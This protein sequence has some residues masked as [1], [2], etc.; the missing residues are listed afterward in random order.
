MAIVDDL[1]YKTTVQDILKEPRLAHYAIDY[2]LEAGPTLLRPY[3]LQYYDANRDFQNGFSDEIMITLSIAVGDYYTFVDPNHEQLFFEITLTPIGESSDSVILDSPVRKTRYKAIGSAK[4]DR[5]LQG[6][7]SYSD[8]STIMDIRLQLIPLPVYELRST[9]VGGIFH[10][11][12]AI[13]VLRSTLGYYSRQLALPADVR[14]RGVEFIPPSNDQVRD[15]IIIPH[16]RIYLHNLADYLQRY[17]G[18]IYNQGIG[19][20]FHNQRWFIYPLYDNTLY[21]KSE[22]T[23]DIFVIPPNRM[24]VNDRTF[25]VKD[26]RLQILAGSQISQIAPSNLMYLSRGNGVRFSNASRFFETYAD[27]KGSNVKTNVNN[28]LTE[29][30]F[31]Q[32]KEE[33]QHAPFSSTMFTDNVAYEMSKL[34]Q[35][36]GDT[37]NIKWE[38]SR[39]DLLRP[40]MAVKLYYATGVGTGFETRTGQ[41]LGVQIGIQPASSGPTAAR[42]VA[43]CM[44]TLFIE[45]M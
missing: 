29:F 8:T 41:L 30:T 18:G 31:R 20:Y 10:D 38:H 35:G 23:L 12:R 27:V 4:Q 3:R 14:V 45:P 28:R 15:N 7:P 37:V 42:Y 2:V 40:G 34:A 17:C 25:Q 13:D 39:P 44:L 33:H 16:G 43:S 32:R 24:M 9:M 6:A 22:Y 11:E 19:V 5:N 21:D 36:V 1:V 26:Q